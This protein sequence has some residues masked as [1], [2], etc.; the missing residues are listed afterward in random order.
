MRRFVAGILVFGLL[1]PIGLLASPGPA[2]AKSK[3]AARQRGPTV[4]QQLQQMQ[5]QLKQQQDQMQQQQTQINQLQ[6]QLQQANSQIQQTQQQGQQLQ[7]SVQQVTQQATTTQQTA[8]TLNT[9]VAD[10]KTNTTQISQNVAETQKQVKGLET[11]PAIHF[12]GVTLTPGGFLASDFLYRTRNE[13]ADVASNF[14]SV[15]FG[16][17]ANSHLSEF[18]ASA[19]VSR[20]TLL[21]EGKVGSAK[22]SGFYEMDFLGEAPTA[23]QVET[24]SFTPRVRQAWG[25]VDLENG[26][27]FTAGQMWS[28]IVTDRKGIATRAEFI[29]NTIEASYVV[30]WDYVRQN[31]VRVTKNFNDRVWAAFEVANPETTFATSFTPTTVFGLNNS[32]NAQSPNGL[33]LNFLPGACTAPTGFQCNPGPSAFTNGLSTNLAPDLIAKVAFEPGWGHYEI[34]AIGRFFRNRTNG[35]TAAGLPSATVPTRTNHNYGGGIGAAAILPVVPKKADLILEGLVGSGIGRYGAALGPDVTLRP[36]GFIVPIKAVHFLGGLELHPDPKLDVFFY[37]G[38]EYYQRTAYTTV[39]P[40]GRTVAAGYGSSLVN[41]TNCNA[42]VLPATIGGV[43]V[44]ACGAQ[45]KNV[46]EGTAGLWYRFYKGSY[47][48]FQYGAQYEYLYRNTWAGIGGAPKGI[49]SIV[50][51]SFRYFLP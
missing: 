51:T 5:D 41:N 37:G 12:K 11:P 13:N 17:I 20:L 29:P 32:P 3:R 2:K 7:S 42:E 25:Q 48:T 14:G 46:W 39:N 38:D 31:A 1:A 21:A 45:N 35:T 50:M 4:S 30:G 15:P 28:L 19:R 47:G 10:L 40:E 8:E 43:A 33:T 6:Q 16:G 44:P 18:R 27:T 26:F 23:N 36:D 49:D 22:L 9:S 34:K 24:N